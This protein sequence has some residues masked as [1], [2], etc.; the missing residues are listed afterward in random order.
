M[1][2]NRW[3]AAILMTSAGILLSACAG[4]VDY[5][6][7]AAR[8]K[9]DNEK[10]INRARDDVWNKSVPQLGRMFFVINNLDKS[11]GLINISYSGDPARYIDCGRIVSFV[12]NARGERTYD[13][14]A[15]RANQTYEVMAPNGL[16]FIERKLSLEGRMNLIF[17][18][19]GS[20]GTRVSANTRYVVTRSQTVRHAANNIPQSK[21]DTISFTSYDGAAFPAN[22]DGRAAECRSTGVLER[23][24]LDAIN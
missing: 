22:Q 17:E 21:T 23:E 11:S 15:A 13:F 6:G 3:C 12:Q 2:S 9:A 10:T 20:N 4:K 16:Y 18:E 7:P 14:P 8:A 1:T 5:Y 19:L 24:V